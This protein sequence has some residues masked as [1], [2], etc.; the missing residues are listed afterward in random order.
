VHGRNDEL[1]ET[2]ARFLAQL[3]LKPIVLHEQPSARNL[4]T[5]MRQPVIEFSE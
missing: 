3:D 5:R 1:K 2:V 4:S